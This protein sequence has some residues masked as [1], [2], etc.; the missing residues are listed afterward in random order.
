[1]H[2]VD[3]YYLKNVEFMEYRTCILSKKN[4]LLCQ[5]KKYE[6]VLTKIKLFKTIKGKKSFS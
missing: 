2:H 4:Y 3:N 5:K 6:K 1:M